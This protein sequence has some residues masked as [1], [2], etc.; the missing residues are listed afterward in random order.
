MGAYHRLPVRT[1]DG[2]VLAV[3]PGVASPLVT[4]T[5]VRPPWPWIAIAPAMVAKF[6][7]PAECVAHRCPGH[8]HKEPLY[9]LLNTVGTV[10]AELHLAR[11]THLR[12]H[13]GALAL[14]APL[15]LASSPPHVLAPNAE[16]GMWFHDLPALATLRRTISEVN[17]GGGGGCDSHFFRI[18]RIFFRIFWAGPLV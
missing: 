17:A 7:Y 14:L 6:K 15:G 8:P 16:P 5:V 18:F 13:H 12:E 10:S 4:A 11:N 9:Y 2:S 3:C 1:P